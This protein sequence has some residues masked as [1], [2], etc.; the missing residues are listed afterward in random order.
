MIVFID[1][2]Q[3][4]FPLRWAFVRKFNIIIGIILR[5]YHF[6]FIS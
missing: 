5:L 1:D 2:D 6:I 4:Q 3:L